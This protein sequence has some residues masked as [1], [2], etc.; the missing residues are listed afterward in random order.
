[1]LS[2]VKLHYKMGLSLMT[3]GLGYVGLYKR[4][5]CS[6]QKPVS[7]YSKFSIWWFFFLRSHSVSPENFLLPQ[8]NTCQ[9]TSILEEKRSGKWRDGDCTAHLSWCIHCLNSFVPVWSYPVL[10]CVSTRWLSTQDLSRSVSLSFA[11][12]HRNG[13]GDLKF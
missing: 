7:P 2:Q 3:N 12:L 1:M 10:R 4:V 5:P 6:N 13:V 8:G 11:R 9:V